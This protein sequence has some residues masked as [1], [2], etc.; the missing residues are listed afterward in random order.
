MCIWLG[1]HKYTST[2]MTIYAE[3]QAHTHT[4]IHT[5]KFTHTHKKS[6]QAHIHRCALKY[7]HTYSTPMLSALICDLCRGE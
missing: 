3:A 6:T 5:V 2:Q 1:I 7:T 4:Q